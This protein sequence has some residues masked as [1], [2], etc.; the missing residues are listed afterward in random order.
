[1]CERVAEY[2]RPGS[3]RR[4]FVRKHVSKMYAGQ[5][6]DRMDWCTAQEPKRLAGPRKEFSRDSFMSSGREADCIDCRL[7]LGHLDFEDKSESWIVHA[8]SAI[9]FLVFNAIIPLVMLRG[10]FSKTSRISTAMCKLCTALSIGNRVYVSLYNRLIS[11]SH[12]YHQGAIPS[13]FCFSPFCLSGEFVLCLEA[14]PYYRDIKLAHRAESGFGRATRGS[15]QG[16]RTN[17]LL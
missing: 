11:I 16:R 5:F 15:L 14:R 1:M 17:S 4:H 3:L 9:F 10:L 6:I 2:S 13:H 12:T 7:F 8:C